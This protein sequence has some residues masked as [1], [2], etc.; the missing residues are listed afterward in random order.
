ME[1]TFFMVCM[2]LGV[3]AAGLIGLVL[4]LV[5]LDKISV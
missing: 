3:M 4:L 1:Q 5:A 2:V